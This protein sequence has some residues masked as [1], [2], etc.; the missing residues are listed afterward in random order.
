METIWNS[1]SAQSVMAIM[2]I[3]RIICL[4]MSTEKAIDKVGMKR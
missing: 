3:V 2:N 1:A 4:H